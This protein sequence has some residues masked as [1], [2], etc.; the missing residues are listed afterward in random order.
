MATEEQRSA[1]ITMV[2]AMRIDL[3]GE[4]AGNSTEIYNVLLSI[5]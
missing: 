1:L 5:R 2:E 4:A 3:G